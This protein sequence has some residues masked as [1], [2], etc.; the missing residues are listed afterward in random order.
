MNIAVIGTG[1]I[2]TALGGAWNSAR[3][4]VVF[5]SRNPGGEK[6]G[7]PVVSYGEA[8]GGSEVVV[9][10]IPGSAMESTVADM[11]LDAKTII[12]CT[13]G[14]DSSERTTVQM[15]RDAAP[16]AVVAKAFN[17]LGFENFDNPLFGKN[18]PDLLYVS[19]NENRTAIIEEL[20][21]QVGLVP[22]RLGD[23]GA[24]G[25]LDLATRFWFGLAGVFGRHVTYK[26][27]RD[28]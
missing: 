11:N 13:N 20:I 6:S 24:V 22:V 2:G 16:S 18:R 15:I 27:L 14:G 28:E 4:T 26:I 9:F 21:S 10:A 17:T 7:I 23:L 25:L 12:D 3:H 19:S 8:V 5:G 1:R